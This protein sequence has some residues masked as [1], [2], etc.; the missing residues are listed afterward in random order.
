M[1]VYIKFTSNLTKAIAKIE[2]AAFERMIDAVNEVRNVTVETLSGNRSGEIY[3][4]MAGSVSKQKA[5]E[6]KSSGHYQ[7][8]A[9]NI[10]VGG[11]KKRVYTASAPGE[12]PASLTGQLRQSVAGEAEVVG[13]SIIGIVGT[14]LDKGK[15]LEYGTSTMAARPW[16][17]K[18]FEKAGENIKGIFQTKWL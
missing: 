10:T 13:G 3:T 6:V 14:N 15:T 4:V 5:N 17:R 1:G 2:D 16:L 12:A 11:K 7:I 8:A 18:S 9:S